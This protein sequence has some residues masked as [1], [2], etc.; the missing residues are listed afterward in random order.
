MFTIEQTLA[1]QTYFSYAM[2][3]F[4]F[5]LISW[6][7]VKNWLETREKVLALRRSVEFDDRTQYM[8]M[9]PEPT[10]SVRFYGVVSCYVERPIRDIIKEPWVYQYALALTKITVGY[11]R[12]KYGQ[13]P[14]FGGQLFSQDIMT[15]GQSEKERLEQDLFT[16]SAGFG[17]SDPVSFFIG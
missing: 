12:G 14:L 5:D 13:V 6:Y 15:Q 16:T 2:G 9:Y 1:Q 8:R 11:V 7:C 4:G 10:D 17:S 3:N